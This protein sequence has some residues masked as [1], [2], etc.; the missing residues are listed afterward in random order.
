MRAQ[1]GRRSH[2]LASRRRVVRAPRPPPTPTSRT[3]EA[4][5]ARTSEYRAGFSYSWGLDGC[6]RARA[7]LSFGAPR[8]CAKRDALLG[9]RRAVPG[10][11]LIRRKCSGAATHRHVSEGSEGRARTRS[12]RRRRPTRGRFDPPPTLGP[13]P[14]ASRTA[15][16]GARPPLLVPP[17][18]NAS[19]ADDATPN[20]SIR[21]PRR[22]PCPRCSSC[23]T[24]PRPVRGPPLPHAHAGLSIRPRRCPRP[25]APSR[26]R[27]PRR[28]PRPD[29]HRGR[30]RP[31]RTLRSP[32]HHGAR[33]LRRRTLRSAGPPDASRAADGPRADASTPDASRAAD[34]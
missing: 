17:T 16:A 21:C 11:I 28:C 14:D 4:A 34:V 24:T 30:R 2:D 31:R 9:L 29:A 19:R 33:T 10:F 27:R 13:R 22:C 1:A 12:S 25:D 3:S 8:P 23:P 32:A 20:A 6:G 18:P 5:A 15:D 7:F 26:R